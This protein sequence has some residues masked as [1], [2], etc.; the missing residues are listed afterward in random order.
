MSFLCTIR[1]ADSTKKSLGFLY[2]KHGG[3]SPKEPPEGAA[4]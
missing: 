2:W 1:G 3:L 4:A